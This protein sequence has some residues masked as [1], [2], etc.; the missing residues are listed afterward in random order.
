MDKRK[1]W[2]AAIAV[3]GV[4][5]V[6]VVVRHTKTEADNQ[7]AETVGADRVAAVV[8][9]EQCWSRLRAGVDGSGGPVGPSLTRPQY[10]HGDS[11]LADLPSIEDGISGTGYAEGRF[12]VS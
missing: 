2:V 10:N 4:L 8:K 3:V 1:W 12:T 11:D 9:V 7:Q 5:L 6:W